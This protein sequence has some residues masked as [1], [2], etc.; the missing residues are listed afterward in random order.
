MRE[1]V[2][3]WVGGG[4]GGGS[5]KASRPKSHIYAPTAPPTRYN[6]TSVTHERLHDT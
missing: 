4:G 1:V 3:V 6:L 5:G 2:V